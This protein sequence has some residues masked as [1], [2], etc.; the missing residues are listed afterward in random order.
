MQVMDTKFGPVV[1]Y[2]YE[3]PTTR[4]DHWHASDDPQSAA[5]SVYVKHMWPVYR[6][7]SITQTS[8]GPD[9]YMVE[10]FGPEGELLPALEI[11]CR[12]A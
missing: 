6:V 2:E 5:E 4:G 12:Y 9:V 8:A 1:R 10:G 7:R 3:M 11:K